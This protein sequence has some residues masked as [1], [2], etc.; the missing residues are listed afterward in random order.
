[1]D[2]PPPVI[3]AAVRVGRG[4]R[5]DPGAVLLGGH[6]A[7]EVAGAHLDAAADGVDVGV[8]EAGDQQAA[9]EVDHLGARTDQLGHVGMPDGDDAISPLTATAV[10]RLRAALPRWTGPPVKTRSACTVMAP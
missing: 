5:R 9:G 8:L 1:M 2:Q 7:G 3:Q 10:A 6:H 4:V